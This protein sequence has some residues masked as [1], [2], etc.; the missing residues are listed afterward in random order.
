MATQLY[1]NRISKATDPKA[2]DKIREHV[3]AILD[4]LGDDTQISESEFR[5]LR[6]IADK[7]K[8]VTDDV[9]AVMQE[10]PEFLEEPLTLA[11]IQK[12]KVFYEFCDQVRAIIAPLA[13]KLDREQNIAGAE[14]ANACSVYEA[15]V[16]RKIVL[17]N[18]KARSVKAQLNAID[19]NR[20]GGA[21]QKTA[22]KPS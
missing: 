5:S 3:R 2:L 18:A 14:Y 21:P 16:D 11:E 20:G 7:S 12:D 19:R 15:N 10:N 9:H 22:E 17:G 1:P 8:R 4:L 6:K 13:V